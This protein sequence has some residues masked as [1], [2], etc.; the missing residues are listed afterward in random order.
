MLVSDIV[1]RVAALLDDGEQTYCT[2]DWVLGFAQNEYEVLF[3]KLRLCGTEFDDVVIEL[4]NVA[5]GTPDL[6]A[7]MASGQ[8]LATLV[9]PRMI[10]WKPAGLPAS[11]PNCNAVLVFMI[12]A[13]AGDARGNDKWAAKYTAR[14][15]DAFDD[16]AIALTRSEQ[17]KT[18]RVSR[19][20]R[21]RRS[22]LGGSGT[23]NT[24]I[25]QMITLP[26]DF[27]ASSAQGTISGVIDGI[28][29]TFLLPR[30]PN[31]QTSLQWFW[32][33]QKLRI[34]EGIMLAGQTVT[35]QLGYI[36]QVG[37][38]LEAYFTA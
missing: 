19:I 27:Y 15:V 10:E 37:D 17:A 1:S 34:G 35:C 14:A 7:F 6:S 9:Q 11:N 8:P 24:G 2:D 38:D 30:A 20:S 33:G 31:P 26:T 16:L 28:N 3:N 36:P 22:G 18:R 29:P 5:A 32:N 4:P 25:P 21:P 23:G 12:A 13:T